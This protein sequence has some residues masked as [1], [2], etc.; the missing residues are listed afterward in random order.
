MLYMYRS[1]YTGLP[2]KKRI[3]LRSRFGFATEL[4]FAL[5]VQVNVHWA[6]EEEKDKITHRRS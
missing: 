6:A 2:K 3:Q 1:V 5:H 4:D